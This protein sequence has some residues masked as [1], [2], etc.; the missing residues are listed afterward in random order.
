VSTA[1][2]VGTIDDA[3]LYPAPRPGVRQRLLVGPS[4]LGIEPLLVAIAVTYVGAIAGVLLAA[5]GPLPEAALAELSRVEAALSAGG[6]PGDL[7]AADRPPLFSLLV[8]PAALLGGTLPQDLLLVLPS[9][10]AGGA[11]A[12]TIDTAQRGRGVPLPIRLATTALVVL[13]PVSLYL[14][15]SALPTL[16]AAACVVIGMYGILEWIRTGDLRWMLL[17]S[18]LF[19]A[20]TLLWY[21]VLIWSVAALT[22]ILVVS[23]I[24][25]GGTRGTAGALI[26]YALP[27]VAAVG[28][29]TLAVERATG[30][31]VPWLARIPLPGTELVMDTTSFLILIAPCALATLAA[32]VAM[33]PNRPPSTWLTI[34]ALAFVPLAVVIAWRVAV[35][36][37]GGIG[38]S[39]FVVVP[40]AAVLYAAIVQGELFERSRLA[41]YAIVIAL[42]VA[43]SGAMALW[44]GASADPLTPSQGDPH[45]ITD[46]F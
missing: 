37:P 28:L 36:G 1:G 3:I 15:A 44:F 4:S 27:I 33:S 20:G 2:D 31:L 42:L 23:A 7:V 22:V 12:G 13:N 40:F 32:L 30:E 26:L 24:S 29:W 39:F 18:L 9:A 46:A 8:M 43:M 45:S 41:L 14:M 21:P 35:G 10:L 6:L 19:A 34:G 25:R 16:P 38:T 5:N 11:I 17:S